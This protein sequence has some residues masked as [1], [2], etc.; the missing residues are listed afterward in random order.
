MLG[1]GAEGTGEGEEAG[2]EQGEE[3]GEE[4]LDSGEEVSLGFFW[5]FLVLGGWGGRTWTRRS[6]LGM[7]VGVWVWVSFCR[8]DA[9]KNVRCVLLIDLLYYVPSLERGPATYRSIDQSS[10]A[11]RAESSP[12]QS[13]NTTATPQASGSQEIAALLDSRTVAVF[14]YSCDSLPCDCLPLVLTQCR[15]SKGR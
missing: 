9:C 7:R 15:T 2:E 4:G 6:F 10:S 1:A 3:D 5:E 11:R 13:I 8:C 14:N 12:V